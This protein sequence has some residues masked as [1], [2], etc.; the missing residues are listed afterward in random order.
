MRGVVLAGARGPGFAE[1]TDFRP[2]PMIE[3]GG[4]P[5]LWHIM[6][7]YSSHGINDFIICL[8]YKG[9]VIKEYFSNYFLHQSNVSF[10]LRENRMEVLQRHAEPWRGKVIAT[11][12]Q[13]TIAGHHERNFPLI[14]GIW[15]L[16]TPPGTYRVRESICQHS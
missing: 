6:K 15:G 1:E 12:T 3:I 4:K 2:K 8:G 10:D 14:D 5:I 9:Y 16:P 13:T 11:G 7:I